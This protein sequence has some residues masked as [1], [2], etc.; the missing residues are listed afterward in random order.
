[1]AIEPIFL[2]FVSVGVFSAAS[3]YG[4]FPSKSLPFLYGISLTNKNMANI[5]RAVTGLYMAFAVF[6]FLSAFHIEL[7]FSA[8]LSLILFMSGIAFGRIASIILDGLP[9]IIIVGYL[10]MELV[11]LSMGYFLI[12]GIS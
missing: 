12:S 8:I 9:D 3:G 11:L 10:I 4:V 2:I 6:W 1:M 7:Y 5:F